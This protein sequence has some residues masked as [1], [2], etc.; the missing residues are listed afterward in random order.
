MTDHTYS[1]EQL[2]HFKCGKCNNWWTIS[3]FPVVSKDYK[4][5]TCPHCSTTLSYKEINNY[6]SE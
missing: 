2:Y 4:E 6:V 3:D 1:I 5:I